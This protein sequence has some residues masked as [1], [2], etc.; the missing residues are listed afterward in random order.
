[1]NLKELECAHHQLDKAVAEACIIQA[2]HSARLGL[3]EK[4][5]DVLEDRMTKMEVKT[6]KQTAIWSALG[7]SLPIVLTLI[8]WYIK[9]R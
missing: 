3:L 2:G 1:M 9:T 4:T 7:A 8:G 5:H 6:A